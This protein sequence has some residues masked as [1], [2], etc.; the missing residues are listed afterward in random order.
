M[1]W[2]FQ[3]GKIQSLAKLCV[4]LIQHVQYTVFAGADD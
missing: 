1:G 3:L 2:L 4:V